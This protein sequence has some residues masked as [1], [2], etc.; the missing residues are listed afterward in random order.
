MDT[1]H[2][3]WSDEEAAQVM[4]RSMKV[5]SQCIQWT[6]E[7][8]SGWVQEMDTEFIEHWQAT[9]ELCLKLEE[10]ALARMGS[11]AQVKPSE[12]STI[13]QLAQHVT[14]L[15][16]ILCGN[17]KE[18]VQLAE[19]LA[20]LSQKTLHMQVLIKKEY[21]GVLNGPQSDEW[22][23]YLTPEQISQMFTWVEENRA[24]AEAMGESR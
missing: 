5:L 20:S 24:I 4:A 3:G 12:L 14:R 16:S 17:P 6:E 11:K 22:F 19:K 15:N 21:G 7:F 9:R 8:L 2:I 13:R 10:G 1:T 23:K 18:T